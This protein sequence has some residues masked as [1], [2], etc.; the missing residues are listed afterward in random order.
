M[1]NSPQSLV[2][3]WLALGEF[4]TSSDT[5]FDRQDAVAKPPIHED[6]EDTPIGWMTQ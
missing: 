2:D 1:M 6:G 4:T 3:G 5:K